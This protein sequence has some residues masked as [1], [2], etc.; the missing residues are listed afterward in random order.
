MEFRSGKPYFGVRPAPEGV[1]FSWSPKYAD[2]RIGVTS[3][4]QHLPGAMY[5][6]TVSLKSPTAREASAF[7]AGGPAWD[8]ALDFEDG[9]IV[10]AF[11]SEV[12]GFGWMRS[13]YSWH[14]E[15]AAWDADF[16]PEADVPAEVGVPLDFVFVDAARDTLEN[17][18]RVAMPGTFVGPLQ[19]AI[20]E[21]MNCP[22]DEEKYDAAVQRIDALPLELIERNALARCTVG[23]GAA[24]GGRGPRH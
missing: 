18:R 22:F 24:G 12:A 4:G 19:A 8:L 7:R 11:R 15:R 9:V 14:L 2:D 6:L 13:F 20:L 5:R 23:G 21:Q 16:Q 1:F 17:I 10:V 3:T